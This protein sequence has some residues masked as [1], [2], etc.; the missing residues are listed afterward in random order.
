MKAQVGMHAVSKY[1]FKQGTPPP[2][3]TK[4]LEKHLLQIYVGMNNAFKL[5]LVLLNSAAF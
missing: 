1:N 2:Q 5:H 4:D 3:P